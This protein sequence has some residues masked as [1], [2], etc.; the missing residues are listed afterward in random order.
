[1]GPLARSQVADEPAAA[2][3][4][5]QE[6]SVAGGVHLQVAATAV[7]V[8]VEDW[9]ALGRGSAEVQGVEGAIAGP[10]AKLLKATSGSD[11]WR[12]WCA[13]RKSAEVVRRRHEQQT[14]LLRRSAFAGR[15]RRTSHRTRSSGRMGAT[16]RRLRACLAR[17][18]MIS[19]TG[20]WRIGI[21]ICS[22]RKIKKVSGLS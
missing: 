6:Q 16:S 14:A 18:T 13:R 5:E 12:R 8:D 7:V 15:R 20:R 21:M 2:E 11:G 22:E 1:M 9:P 17:L 4:G 10:V 19:E 3:E